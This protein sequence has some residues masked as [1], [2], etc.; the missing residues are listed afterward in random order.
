MPERRRPGASHFVGA[1]PSGML[2]ITPRWGRSNNSLLGASKPV[3]AP[4]YLA[5]FRMGRDADDVP[6]ER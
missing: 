3:A 5:S 1:R 2:E 6:E 4:G